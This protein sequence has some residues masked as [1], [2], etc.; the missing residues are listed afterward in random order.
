MAD[1]DL[2]IS[3]PLRNAMLLAAAIVLQFATAASAANVTYSDTA[4]ILQQR[5]V[6]CHS[7]PAAPR[8]LR[9]DSLEGLLAGSENGAVVKSVDA[10][11][12]ELIRRLTGCRF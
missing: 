12:S 5:C 8:G 10:A 11:G 7:G 2:M 9:L 3:G 6:M 4:P 1:T